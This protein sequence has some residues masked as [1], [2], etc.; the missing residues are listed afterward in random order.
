MIVFTF[1]FGTSARIR[2]S[3]SAALGLSR[4]SINTVAPFLAHARAQQKPIPSLVQPVI[5]IVLPFKSG[6]VTS[7]AA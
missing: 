6:T 3:A 2:R 7:K 1:A 4:L 5:A